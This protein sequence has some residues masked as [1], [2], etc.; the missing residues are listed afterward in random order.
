MSVA[1]D[2]KFEKGFNTGTASPASFVSNAGTVTGSVGVNANRVLIVNVTCTNF[3]AHMGNVTMKATKGGSLTAMTL[4][5]SADL[6]TGVARSQYQYGMM[7]PDTGNITLEFSWDSAATD[8]T[9]YVGAVSV[10]NADQVT[11]WTNA[12]I[13]SGTGTD[14]DSTVTTTAGNMAVVGH[15]NDN[16]SSTALDTV[17]HDGTSAWIDTSLNTNAAM[18]YFADNDGSAFIGWNLGSSVFWKNLRVDVMTAI[19]TAQ[20][21]AAAMQEGQSWSVRYV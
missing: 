5:Q 11:G 19:T 13:D 2:A 14:A 9:I 7:A 18:A 1:F 12:G 20:M 17:G 4:I 3:T 8:T 10:Y 21:A 16:A 15:H 6:G